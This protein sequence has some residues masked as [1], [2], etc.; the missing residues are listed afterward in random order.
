MSA[1]VLQEVEQLFQSKGIPQIREAEAALRHQVSEKTQELRRVVGESYNDLIATADALVE[2]SSCASEITHEVEGIRRDVKELNERVQLA[3]R[4]PSKAA[5]STSYEA[6]FALG[7]RVKFLLDTPE[8]VWACLEEQDHLG[9]A[10]RFL[11]ASDL[12][13]LLSEGSGG[14]PLG[15]RFPLLHHQWPTTRALRNEVWEHALQRLTARCKAH[16]R[17]EKVVGEGNIGQDEAGPMF[18]PE[19]TAQT[20]AA[21]LLLRPLGGA[22]LLKTLLKA[23]RGALESSLEALELHGASGEPEQAA[24]AR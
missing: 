18:D 7:S 9:A 4:E 20:L 13:R 12:H 11:Q 19:S 8:A 23:V 24:E 3:W 1:D 5:A 21:L 17:G 2:I 16:M 6:Q 22:E 15:S 14:G 10:A